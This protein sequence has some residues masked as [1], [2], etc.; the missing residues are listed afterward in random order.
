MDPRSEERIAGRDMVSPV[1]GTLRKRPHAI[2][3]PLV[4]TSIASILL[5]VVF[6]TS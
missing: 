5:L 6:N 1:G 3:A 4:I 2:L